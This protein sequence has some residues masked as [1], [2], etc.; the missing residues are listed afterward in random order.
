MKESG[1][2]KNTVSHIKKNVAVQLAGSVVECETLD[3]GLV[4]P[5][6]TLYIE[7]T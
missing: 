7:I 5:S 1:Q 3:L 6:P 4:S 2:R